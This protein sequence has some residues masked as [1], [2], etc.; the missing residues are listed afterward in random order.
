MPTGTPFRGTPTVG[1]LFSTTSKGGLGSHFCTASV[2]DSPRKD[3]AITAAHCVTHRG[4]VIK[5]VPGYQAGKA[6]YGIWTVSKVIVDQA[7]SSSASI[8]DDVAFLIISPRRGGANIEDLTGAERLRIG[9]TASLPVQVIGYPDGE[10]QPVTC[11]GRTTLPL[12]H[13]LQFDCG[14]YTDGT[15]GGPFLL[16]VQPGTGDGIVIGVIG[17]YQQGGDLPQISYAAAFGTNVAK[18]YQTAIKQS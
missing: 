14:K 3:L 5:F 17:G 11:R 12:P 18:L 8:D 4:G 9:P 1:A 7:W 15:S 16:N 2:V 13:Q 6:A 10:D